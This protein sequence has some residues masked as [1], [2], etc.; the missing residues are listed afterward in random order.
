MH[1]FEVAHCFVYARNV[2]EC[3]RIF[4]YYFLEFR[5]LMFVY[6]ADNQLFFRV[7]V[8]TL[9]VDNRNAVA[10]LAHKSVGNFFGVFRG[11]DDLKFNSGFRTFEYFVAH[12]CGDKAVY[13]TENNRLCLVAVYE[14]GKESDGNVQH[15]YNPDEAY[16]RFP[17]AHERGYDIR[18]ARGTAEFQRNSV[19]KAVDRCG[20]DGRQNRTSA[21]FGGV[22]E[23]I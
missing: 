6:N 5:Y 11:R 18:A 4:A 14:V 23:F 16:M 22:Y 15:K 3:L 20:G 1:F 2:C 12:G 7:G 19:Y 21:V 10:K 13:D 17:F 9:C 8:H